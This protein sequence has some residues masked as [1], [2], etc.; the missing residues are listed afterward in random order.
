[1][2]TQHVLSLQAAAGSL[3]AALAEL[4]MEHYDDSEDDVDADG[5]GLGGI[6]SGEGH[7]SASVINR[8]LGGSCAGIIL[9]DPYMQGDDSSDEADDDQVRL[10]G[11]RQQPRGGPFQRQTADLQPRALES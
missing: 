5:E 8:A 4:D 1:M 7:A 3:E 9:D 6:Q 2:L 11:V 10:R